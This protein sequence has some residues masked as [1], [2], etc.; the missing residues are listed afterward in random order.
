MTRLKAYLRLVAVLMVMGLVVFAAPSAPAQ[1]VGEEPMTLLRKGDLVGA[2]VRRPY[3][4]VPRSGLTESD[5]Y[6]FSFEDAG[7]RCA[8]LNFEGMTDWRI[9]SPQEAGRFV[10]RIQWEGLPDYIGR[11]LKPGYGAGDVAVWTN[12]K[13]KDN[14]SFSFHGDGKLH[15]YSSRSITLCVREAKMASAPPPVVQL[16]PQPEPK[17]EKKSERSSARNFDPET[18]PVL[19]RQETTAERMARQAEQAKPSPQAIAAERERV[20]E[21]ARK[22]AAMQV[23]KLQAETRQRQ[24]CLLPQAQGACGCTRFQTPPPGGWKVCGK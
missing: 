10:D 5:S 6:L 12:A 15:A 3:K 9:P 2:V 18:M 7:R 4:F 19:T 16:P 8:Q 17:M 1:A 23:A 21:A 13:D 11:D 20:R 14:R 24:Q 22:E